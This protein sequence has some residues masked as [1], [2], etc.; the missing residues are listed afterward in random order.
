MNKQTNL[1]TNCGLIRLENFKVWKTFFDKC[2]EIASCCYREIVFNQESTFSFSCKNIY[3]IVICTGKRAYWGLCTPF[4]FSFLVREL[5]CLLRLLAPTWLHDTLCAYFTVK[6]YIFFYITFLLRCS[7]WRVSHLFYYMRTRALAILALFSFKY[8]SFVEEKT[9]MD[10]K[11]MSNWFMQLWQL[12]GY[13]T[14]GR[15]ALKKNKLQI[16]E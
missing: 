16:L 1:S 3:G 14:S 11:T 6:Y 13:Q 8:F 5:Q 10:T 4:F 2:S 9:K 7:F 15:K 12:P